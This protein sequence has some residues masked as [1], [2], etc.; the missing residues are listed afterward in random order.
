M[1]DITL[2]PDENQVSKLTESTDENPVVMV[3]LLK[4]REE[5]GGIDQGMSGAEAYGKYSMEVQRFLEGVGG[6]VLTAVASVD[7]IIGPEEAEW[8]MTILVQYPNRQ[9]FLKMVTD[10]GYLA[11]AGHRTAALADSR[12]I[13]SNSVLPR[14]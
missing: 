7:S 13:L 5:A 2:E 4:F 9:A 1:N 6:K 10:P 11:I 14:D 8:D 12:L 3:N